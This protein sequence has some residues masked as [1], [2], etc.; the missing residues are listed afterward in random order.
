MS[1]NYSPGMPVDKYGNPKFNYV[2]AKV[3]LATTD[4]ENASVSSILLLTHDTT[5]VEVAVVGSIAGSLGAT[6]AG[7]F[8]SGPTIDS[9]VAGTSVITVA[10]SANF[11]FI[12]QAGTTRRFVI[13]IATFKGTSG[14]I[15]GV[16]RE[17]GLYQGIAYKTLTG[18]ASVLTMEF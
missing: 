14:S 15:Q 4:K 6:I 9:S 17:L 13:P 1:S 2:P 10:G 18:V 12:V 5:E 8:L 16:N 3:A 11:D 7:K